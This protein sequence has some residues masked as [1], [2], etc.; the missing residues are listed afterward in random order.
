MITEKKTIYIGNHNIASQVT[1][2]KIGLE[3]QGHQVFVGVHEINS[4]ITE[5]D[6]DFNFSLMKK[7]KFRGVRPIRLQRKLQTYFSPRNRVFRRMVRQCDIFIF[8]WSSFESDRSDYEY[9]KKKGKKI[10]TFFVGSDIRWLPAHEQR[11]KSLSLLPIKFKDFDYSSNSLL[12]KLRYLR[13][14][15]KF[16]DLIFALPETAEL[17]IRPYHIFRLFSDL[18]YYI[19]NSDQNEIPQI[20]HIPSNPEIKGTKHILKAIEKLKNRG[21]KF[22]FKFYTNISRNKAIEYYQKADIVVGQMSGGTLAKQ[23]IEVL[24]S[25]TIFMTMLDPT[26]AQSK[27]Y[28]KSNPAIN[29]DVSCLEKELERVIAMNKEDRIS[30]AKKGRPFVEKYHDAIKVSNEIISF[31]DSKH[32]YDHIPTFFREQ[33][34]PAKEELDILNKYTEFVKD[35][36]WYEKHVKPGERDGLIF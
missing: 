30:L 31:L 23:G 12:T 34:K 1:D 29:V 19:E 25:G 7:Y 2:L 3:K 18:S 33:Y 10:I 6:V 13:V 26:L 32:T 8:V 35:C 21:L 36:D 27:E 14:A 15:E 22:E 24:A 11:Q 17:A 28:F 9:L 4:I 16:S 20:I 5:S